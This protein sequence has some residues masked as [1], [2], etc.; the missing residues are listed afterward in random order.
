MSTPT[1]D[2]FLLPGKLYCHFVVW[3]ILSLGDDGGQQD[4]GQ[5]G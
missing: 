1:E 4:M 2:I 5:F 3:I